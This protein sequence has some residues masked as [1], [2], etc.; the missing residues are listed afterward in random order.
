MGSELDSELPLE[1][2]PEFD[3]ALDAESVADSYCGVESDCDSDIDP[4]SIFSLVLSVI[5]NSVMSCCPSLR[6]ELGYGSVPNPSLVLVLILNSVSIEF[7]K[8]GKA[9]L[10][11]TKPELGSARVLSI[12]AIAL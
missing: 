2:D 1:Y 4:G 11:F 6:C 10:A 3:L 5:L 8:T 9:D 7:A 12:F